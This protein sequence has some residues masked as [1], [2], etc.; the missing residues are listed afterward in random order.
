MLY[1]AVFN[2]KRNE[3]KTEFSDISNPKR[4]FPKDSLNANFKDQ[5][6]K[7]FENAY[8]KLDGVD[9]TM[10]KIE[11]Y[12]KELNHLDKS[13]NLNT[14]AQKAKHRHKLFQEENLVARYTH[15]KKITSK[16]DFEKYSGMKFL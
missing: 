13:Y 1:L 11:D 9:I 2:L 14:R 16:S 7:R 5:Q 6:K 4:P 8:F 15:G 12:L 3:N 10:Q